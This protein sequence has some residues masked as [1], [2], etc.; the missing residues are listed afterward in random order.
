[1]KMFFTLLLIAAVSSSNGYRFSKL[2]NPVNFWCVKECTFLIQAM[3]EDACKKVACNFG[4][5]LLI[6]TL[7]FITFITRC[8]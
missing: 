6:D 8:C 2:F 5:Y 1:M 7:E 4:N 3:P